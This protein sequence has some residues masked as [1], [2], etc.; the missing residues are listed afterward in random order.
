MSLS[1]IASLPL[2]RNLP[3]SLREG[4]NNCASIQNA[5][6]KHEVQAFMMALDR[7]DDDDDDQDLLFIQLSLDTVYASYAAAQNRVQQY[8][9]LLTLLKCEE[10]LWAQRVEKAKYVLPEYQSRWV[11]NRQES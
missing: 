1:S 6:R 11:S 9:Q 10:D 2:S 4:P 8:T 3:G 7:I 5:D